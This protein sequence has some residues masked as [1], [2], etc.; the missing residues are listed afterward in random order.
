[1]SSQIPCS[2]A[3]WAGD[4]LNVAGQLGTAKGR[5]LVIADGDGRESQVTAQTRQALKNVLDIVEANGL[6]A[7]DVVK[8]TVYLVKWADYD[9]MHAEYTKIFPSSSDDNPPARMTMAVHELWNN[10]LVEIDCWAYRNNKA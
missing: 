8:T 9:A 6:T 5:G 1:M 4:L 2:P 3:R 7:A 10:A